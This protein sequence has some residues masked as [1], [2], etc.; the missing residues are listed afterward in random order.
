[1]LNKCFHLTLIHYHCTVSHAMKK[2]KNLI[3]Q[4]FGKLTVI[5]MLGW[6]NGYYRCRCSCECG[7]TK[8]CRTSKL[9]EGMVKSCGCLPVGRPGWIGPHM[10]S[11]T[12]FY[13]IWSGMKAR[14]ENKKHPSYQMYGGRG[15]RVC[16][17]WKSFEGFM[18]DMFSSYKSGLS[19]DRINNDGHYSPENCR[20]ASPSQQSRNTRVSVFLTLDGVTKHRSEWAEE[21][22]ISLET[23]RSRIRNRMP[24]RKVLSPAYYGHRNGGIKKWH[25]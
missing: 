9:K 5:E 4:R 15:I 13:K 11:Q 10:M 14:C 25:S 3:G 1:M 8:V 7:N 19:I 17:N 2:Q 23:I 12:S 22:G 6:I 16:D 20:W 18:N 21:L 24:M